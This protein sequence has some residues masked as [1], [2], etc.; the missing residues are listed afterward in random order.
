MS[1]QRT[2]Y[3]AIGLAEL[4]YPQVRDGL[5]YW[6]SLKGERLFP[7]RQQV[8]PRAIASLLANTILIKVIEGG[9]DFVFTIV[10]D[11]VLRSYRTPF[12]HRRWSELVVDLPHAAAYW[13]DVYRD[14]CRNKK[15]WA[16]RYTPGLDGEAK[17]SKAE[18][19]VL[20]LGPNDDVV[21][22]ILT[23]GERTVCE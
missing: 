3:R 23:F 4:S 15:P 10:G 16:V 20:P 2:T 8:K 1:P 11:E 19:V 6:Q 7:S 17:F 5:Q 18:A 14:I 21:D 22:H 9:K 13:G 12:I